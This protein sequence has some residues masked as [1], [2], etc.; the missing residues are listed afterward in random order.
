MFLARKLNLI[1]GFKRFR[2]KYF[3]MEKDLYQSFSA[4]GQS[5]K[6]LLIACSD[7]R[8]DPAIL[9]SCEPGDMFVIRNVANLVP[10]YEEGGGYHGTSAAIEF[11][12]NQLKVESVVILGHAHCGGIAAL[13]RG[14]V[15][16]DSNIFVNKWV[17]IADEAR[18]KVLETHSLENFREFCHA[19]EQE[20][21]L[22]SLHNL[23]L[24]PFI[25]KKIEEGSL[26]VSG[27]YFDLEKG[28]LWEHSDKTGKF[29][30]L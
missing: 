10:P 24:F 3:V 30:E 7:S 12:V 23:K 29:L 26:T 5:P 22:I 11:A 2:Q 6:I 21:I 16:N 9:F 27:W 18:A 17:T 15:S 14:E 4:V 8:V 13:S 1:D 28:K 19:C 20:A 25:Q